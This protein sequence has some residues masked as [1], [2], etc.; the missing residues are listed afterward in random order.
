MGSVANRLDALRYEHTTA[1]AL[2][3]PISPASTISTI[4]LPILSFLNTV[5]F[6]TTRARPSQ[7]PSNRTSQQ[8]HQ[9][10]LPAAFQILQTI[11]TTVLATTFVSDIIP[12]ATRQC[13]L[14]TRWQRLW[15]GHDAAAIRRIQDTFDCCGFNSVRDRAWPFPNRNNPQPGCAAQFGRTAA[16]A[17]P[18]SRALQTVGGVEFGVVA[19][20]GMLQVSFFFPTLQSDARC[21]CCL[22]ELWHAAVLDQVNYPCWYPSAVPI[23]LWCSG[24]IRRVTPVTGTSSVCPWCFGGIPGGHVFELPWMPGAHIYFPPFSLRLPHLRDPAS[25]QSQGNIADYL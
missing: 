18:W 10:L 7:H 23:L 24:L 14:S 19:A 3:L 25:L 13:L 22:V 6:T 11:I 8:Q 5:Y 20:V 15:T 16:C 2:S 1:A 9:L 12:S 21:F 4:I 17:G